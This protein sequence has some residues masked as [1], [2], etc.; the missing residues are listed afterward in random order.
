MIFFCY[1]KKLKSCQRTLDEYVKISV[2]WEIHFWFGILPEICIF[3]Y[4]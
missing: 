1:S 2:R 3:L 4:I